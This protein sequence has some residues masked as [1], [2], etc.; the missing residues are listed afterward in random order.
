MEALGDLPVRKTA[1]DQPQHLELTLRQDRRLV[2]R[3][4]WGPFRWFG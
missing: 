1:G 3:V 4:G 2:A